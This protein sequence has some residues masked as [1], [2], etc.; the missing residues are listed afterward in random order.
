MSKT[1]AA[2]AL[3]P[4][5]AARIRKLVRGLIL[6]EDADSWKGGGD[7]A[8]FEEIEERLRLARKSFNDYLS[9]LTSR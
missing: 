2:P 3:T 9:A 4:A 1:K 7:P 6:A 5:Q 8:D